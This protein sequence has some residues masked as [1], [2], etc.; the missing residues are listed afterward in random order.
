MKHYSSIE[1]NE[2][3][4]FAVMWMDLGSITQSGIRKRGKQIS[5]NPHT[6]G[7]QKKCTKEPIFS[8]VLEMPT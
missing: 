6:Y 7:I 2:I 5:Y 1:R 8:A 4:S 3:G